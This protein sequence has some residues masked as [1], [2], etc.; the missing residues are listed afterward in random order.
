M[1]APAVS[2]ASPPVRTFRYGPDE[3]QEADLHLPVESS[4]PVACLFHGGF[5]KMPYGREQFE[6]VARD[7]AHRGI[8]AWNIGYR[9]VGAPGGGWPG[10][11][12]DAALA[13]EHL[14]ALTAGGIALDL[15]RVVVAGHSAGGHLALWV[16]AGRNLAGSARATRV[17]PIGAVS[18]AG[19]ADLARAHVLGA[20]GD[21]VERLMGGT[22][23]EHPERYAAA[24]PAELLPLGTSQLVLH[25]AMDEALPAELSRRYVDAA[26]AAG[27]PVDHVELPDAGHMDFLDPAS[28]AH[29]AF[30]GWLGRRFRQAGPTAGSRSS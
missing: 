30:V 26:R 11:L 20:G 18:M 22:P 10:T 24:S 23:L 16:A 14:A 3:G 2:S 25:G 13:V 21:A 28:A 1:S 5:W 17:R 19:I 15:G 6:A 8:A 27:D 9:R 29:A 7:L 12:E 4:P